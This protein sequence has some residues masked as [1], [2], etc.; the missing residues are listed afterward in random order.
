L[1]S[2]LGLAFNVHYCDN[3]IASISLSTIQAAQKAEQDCCG[4]VEKNSKCCNDKI[5]KAE[6]K[7]ELILVKSVSFDAEFI[8]D[9]NYWKPLFFSDNFSFKTRGNFTYYCDSHPPPLYLL[10]SQYTF[11]A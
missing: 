6:I 5:I 4:V 7:S 1:F 11:Y 2:N 10:Y 9:Y 8:Q 3:E